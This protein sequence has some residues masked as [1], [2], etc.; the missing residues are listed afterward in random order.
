MWQQQRDTVVV[1]S[2]KKNSRK[3]MG[4]VRL[5]SA[6]CLCCTA[7]AC[8]IVLLSDDTKLFN[9]IE[10]ICHDGDVLSDGQEGC[11]TKSGF[12]FSLAL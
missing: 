8:S 3:K 9:C 10:W 7:D 11:A 5:L 2:N 12:L 4:R 1:E 6:L